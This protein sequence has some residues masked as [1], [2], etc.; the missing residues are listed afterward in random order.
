MTVAP[1]VFS[2]RMEQHWTETLGN[3][4]NETIEANMEVDC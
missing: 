3:I 2:A 4:A 1:E